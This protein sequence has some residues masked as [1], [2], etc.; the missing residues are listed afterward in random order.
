MQYVFAQIAPG[1][2]S[3]LSKRSKHCC[4]IDFFT[5][6]AKKAATYVDHKASSLTSIASSYIA[7]QVPKAEADLSKLGSTLKAGLARAGS[8]L[9]KLI[10]GDYS[11]TLD[12]PMNIIPGKSSLT[13]S[14]WGQQLLL[15]RIAKTTAPGGQNDDGDD[16]GDGVENFQGIEMFCVN[17]GIRGDFKLTGTIDV[18]IL[19]GVTAASIALAGNLEAD[20]ALG[21][22][23]R[24]KFEENFAVG[25]PASPLISFT[26]PDVVT[27]SP[28]IS[29]EVDLYMKIDAVAQVVIG[30]SLKWP[31]VAGSLDF[32]SPLNSFAAGFSPT[33]DL[34]DPFGA[35][36]TVAMTAGLGLPVALGVDLSLLDG[37]YNYNV[38]L[39]DTPTLN[40]SASY[41][42]EID[43]NGIIV[44]NGDGCYGV[45]WSVGMTNKLEFD[46]GSY[47]KVLWSV[48]SPDMLSGCFGIDVGPQTTA[49]AFTS[50]ADIATGIAST[51]TS[52]QAVQTTPAGT[53]SR[54]TTA[55]TNKPTTTTVIATTSTSPGWSGCTTFPAVQSTDLITFTATSNGQTS[56][57]FAVARQSAAVPVKATPSNPYGPGYARCN[58]VTGQWQVSGNQAPVHVNANGT[59][60]D[61]PLNSWKMCMQKCVADNLFYGTGCLGVYWQANTSTCYLWAQDII[62]GA[63]E[64]GTYS[65]DDVAG[66]VYIPPLICPSLPVTVS[67]IFG[68]SD[69][70]DY[71][72]VMTAAWQGNGTSIVGG[73]VHTATLMASSLAATAALTKCAS[74]AAYVQFD[75]GYQ[76]AVN[77]YVATRDDGAW[78]CEIVDVRPPGG[79]YTY[80][81]AGANAN[82]GCSWGYLETQFG[83]YQAPAV[84]SSSSSTT[85]SATTTTTKTTTTTSAGWGNGGW[86]PGPQQGYGG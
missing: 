21:A 38:L 55:S 76:L 5:S 83:E 7:K 37:K 8:A 9:A 44:N 41:S 70:D 17:C 69:G 48:G 79:A 40:M 74:F 2:A 31:N 3:G 81:P 30:G 36:G 29:V 78:A 54:T 52:V 47:K 15:A 49:T 24:A 73:N 33:V 61:T 20:I 62:D 25:I 13:A 77:L 63:G 64:C 26:I 51:T 42:V 45:D 65:P 80:G 50:P 4:G 84:S 34:S 86:Q 27:V 43:D 59:C 23:A 10:S 19:H 35:N 72:V 60:V 6:E 75:T 68:N 66:D 18:S 39:K 32:L 22:E 67:G 85:S 71:P 57:L 82:I 53:S 28:I 11:G 14:P 58:N 1:L 56:T 12:I 16:V 46:A